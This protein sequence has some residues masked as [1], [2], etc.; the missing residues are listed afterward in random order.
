MTK[1]QHPNFCFWFIKL[2]PYKILIGLNGI[3]LKYSINTNFT[4]Q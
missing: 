4:F 2:T 3:L 1:K